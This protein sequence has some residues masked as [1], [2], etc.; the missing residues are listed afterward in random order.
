[1]TMM[2]SAKNDN[3]H[4][5][6]LPGGNL[7]LD[8]F[9][10]KGEL[11]QRRL[12]AWRDRVGHVIDV[13]PSL[14]QL[15]MPFNASID[16]Y[17]IGDRVFT[18][19]VSDALLLRRSVARISTDNIRDYAF[20]VFTD[21]G[22]ESIGGVHAPRSR[23]GKRPLASIVALDMNQPVRMHRSSC[24]VLTLFV[25]RA[26]VEAALPHAES[27][28]GRV[29]ENTTPLTGLLVEHVAALAKNLPGISA[30]EANKAL[31]SS[32]QL[33]LAAFGK[34]ASLSGNA[35]AAVR[36]A[37]FDKARRYV[38]ANLHQAALSPASLLDALQLPR[39]TMYRLFEHEGGLGAYIRNCRLRE[40]AT[41]LVRFPN[42]PVSKIAYG[43]GFN[44]A[45]D[46]TR[47]FRRAYEMSPQDLRAM[48]LW[49]ISNDIENNAA[50]AG[51]K[52]QRGGNAVQLSDMTWPAAM[53][54]PSSPRTRGSKLPSET[55]KMDSRVR[56]NDA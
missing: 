32:V 26:N 14:A 4:G 30:S 33:L 3:A 8:R 45:S 43:L 39:P 27:I 22:I 35:R 48:A 47:A 11:P 40:A 19:C 9:D 36:A 17:R 25:P 6:I 38:Q 53:A 51:E 41:E 54:A 7:K 13:L 21:G 31:D 49:G 37:M 55:M 24:R 2:D 23:N 5:N 29:F 12:L 44:S 10:V 15:E 20:H 56:G 34:Q 50:G 28:H 52:T 18:D 42:L 16:R 1:M 46:F